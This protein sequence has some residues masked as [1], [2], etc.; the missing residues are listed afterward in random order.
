MTRRFI[1]LM[2]FSATLSML[3]S[4]IA[5]GAGQSQ[6]ATTEAKVTGAESAGAA[7]TVPRVVAFNG[8]LQDRS[9]RPLTGV[10][11]VTFALYKDQE[12]GA[13]LWTE[14]QNLQ[15]DEQGRYS[16]FL[17]ST[18][19]AGVPIELFTS[20]ESRWLGVQAQAP[21]EEE[22]PR[23]LLVSVPYA[24]K[25]AD[26]DTLGGKPASAYLLSTVAE[27]NDTSGAPKSNAAGTVKNTSNGFTSV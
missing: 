27:A 25:A 15:V 19:R 17:G 5:I 8:S 7:V 18:Q 12:G 9:N 4:S 22:K 26:A 16:V 2:A 3:W 13:P 11:G 20:G 21:G 14:V 1:Y 23:V 6:A 24:L 10:V